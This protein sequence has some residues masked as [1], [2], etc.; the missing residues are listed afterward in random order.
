MCPF[1]HLKTQHLASYHLRQRR[2][3]TS[4]SVSPGHQVNEIDIANNGSL[5]YVRPTTTPQAFY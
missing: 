3:T 1:L 5:N 2:A 4:H